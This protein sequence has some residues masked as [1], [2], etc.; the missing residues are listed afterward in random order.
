MLHTRITINYG[1]S[2][3]LFHGN[4]VALYFGSGKYLD[5]KVFEN[6]SSSTC[7]QHPSFE[8]LSFHK[9]HTWSGLHHSEAFKEFIFFKTISKYSF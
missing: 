3:I 6:I 1:L 5:A 7:L 4:V 9:P 2:P 8:N